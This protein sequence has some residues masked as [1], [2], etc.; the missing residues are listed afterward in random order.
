MLIRRALWYLETHRT[1]E[2]TLSSVATAMDV[3]PAYLT[4]AFAT[5]LGRPLMAYLRARRLTEAALK[6]AGGQHSVLTVA[7][8]AS[9]AA[10]EPFARAFRAELGLTPSAVRARRRADDLP[11]TFPKEIAMAPVTRLAPPVIEEMPERRILGP[12]RRYDMQT[13]QGIPGQWADYNM[14]DVKAEGAVPDCWYGVCANFGEGGTFDYLCGQ[15]VPN[16]AVPAGW[17]ALTLPAGRWARFVEAGHISLMQDVWG[18][19]YREW[20]GRPG[21]TPRDAP[22]VEV[23]PLA[24]NGAT[25]EGGFEIWMPVA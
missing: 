18:E 12:L 22:S 9:Y 20:M 17:S 8:D 11:L 16:G 21:L 1:D 25:G 24:F 14:A 19:I 7:L 4:R 13:R 6:L 10:P 23:Y 5:V 2:V 15:E 3:S